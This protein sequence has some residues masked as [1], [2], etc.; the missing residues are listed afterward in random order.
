MH[1]I[2]RLRNFDG[3]V[4]TL[5][6]RGHSVRLG[7]LDKGELVLPES[8]KH[9]NIEIGT[10]AKG[11]GDPWRPYTRPIRRMRDALRYLQPLYRRA[12]KLRER[13]FEGIDF[14]FGQVLVVVYHLGWVRYLLVPFFARLLAFLEEMIPSDE[15]R[16]NAFIR[17]AKPDV[18]LISPLV[19][20]GS[21]YQTDYVKGAHDL[22]IPVAVLP[23][24]WDNL[25]NKGLMR[26]VPDKILVWNEIQKQEAIRL[27]GV[28]ADRVAVCGAW[29][30]DQFF[31][32]KPSTSREDFC[33][34]LKLDPSQPIVTYLCSSE[35]TSGNEADFVKEW[36][37]TLR[38][39]PSERLRRCNLLVRP[40]PDHMRAWSAV[41]LSEFG[42]AAVM[43]AGL[44]GE[45][46]DASWGDQA[47]FDC[48]FH[49]KSVV[50]L[51][52]S[53]MIEAA[54]LSKP[55]H[56]ILVDRFRGGQA[57]TLHFHYFLEAGGGLL[58]VAKSLREHAGLLERSL[59]EVAARDGMSDRFVR[60]FVRPYGLDVEAT[61][62]V[63]TEI[64]ALAQ[65]PKAKRV[66]PAWQEALRPRVLNWLKSL[67]FGF[68]RGGV[69]KG[70]R[71]LAKEQVLSWTKALWRRRYGAAAQPMSTAAP[72]DAIRVDYA[73]ADIHIR[74]NSDQERRW[75]A[76]S[77]AAEPWTV[78]WIE[79]HAQ[80][81]GVFYDIGARL[82][83][84]S[85]L[86][87]KRSNGTGG[88]ERVFAFEPRFSSFARLCENVRLNDCATKVVALP[89][90]LAAKTAFTGGT[91][92]DA[93][94]EDAGR[95]S[96]AF[97]LDDLVSRHGLP[98]PSYI[99]LD[100]SG[101]ELDVLDGATETLRDPALKSVLVERGPQVAG[102][103][104][105][106]L[107]AAGF[108]AGET[109]EKHAFFIREGVS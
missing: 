28:P 22:G 48:L 80:D 45:S 33:R 5:A 14:P 105:E 70:W 24:S 3:V 107:L 47:L 61:P 65:R 43:P 101:F 4:R 34:L 94:D 90:P 89:L 60:A 77:C 21:E 82:G 7:F 59:E 11:R 40:Y 76:R 85:L 9:P 16:I 74:A 37:R 95:S 46:K 15:P 29:R 54:I 51:N 71:A 79:R 39:N 88:R 103:V 58:R 8:L 53:A 27:H 30:F 97:R 78:R 68:A 92:D 35:F 10:C 63:I 1:T 50:G 6:E 26:V 41:D 23:F 13:A 102:P 104:S 25:T 38:K 2:N 66:T 86:S 72:M 18:I 31:A 108:R 83:V 96:L 32:M 19:Q 42:H 109:Q 100:C 93:A 57:D 67:N 52:T 99:R 12:G 49:S 56:T 73:A 36:A 87:A 55:V 81:D 44:L 106:R 20:R 91:D 17:T 64:K 62:R 98:R 75:Q 84:F 69:F